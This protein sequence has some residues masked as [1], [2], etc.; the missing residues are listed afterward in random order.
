M[1][2]SGVI[3]HLRL[4]VDNSDK[5]YVTGFY[6]AN[7]NLTGVI[8][9]RYSKNNLKEELGTEKDFSKMSFDNGKT[10][11]NVP[12]LGNQTMTDFIL[13]DDGGSYAISEDHTSISTTDP[14]YHQ[15]RYASDRNN[16]LVTKFNKDG[17]VEWAQA[18]K[19]NQR[20]WDDDNLNILSYG[21]GIRNNKLYFLFNDNP[22]NLQSI[23]ARA[24]DAGWYDKD[25]ALSLVT[26][27]PDGIQKRMMLSSCDKKCKL[28][29]IPDG[30]LQT[31]K[32]HLL[33]GAESL[34]IEFLDSVHVKFISPLETKDLKYSLDTSK[35][36]IWFDITFANSNT[37]NWIIEFLDE[38]TFKLE[39]PEKWNSKRPDSFKDYNTARF[40]R[41]QE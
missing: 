9:K 36:P 2:H 11:G 28:A 14:T 7:L 6:G 35:K 16:I 18:V 17:N 20:D 15:T 26:I 30:C 10:L 33:V 13:L 38:N 27:A 34:R 5:V 1:E 24:E 39:A 37:S 22:K 23:G 31:D 19:K 32:E 8:Y 40:K 29:I 25:A 12:Y 41:R 3:T 4:A 21:L